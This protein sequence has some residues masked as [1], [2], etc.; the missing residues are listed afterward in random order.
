MPL[1][2]PPPTNEAPP[3]EWAIWYSQALNWKVFPLAPRE[4]TPLT[5]TGFHAA[6]NELAQVKRWWTEHP[7]AGIGIPAGVNQLVLV[8]FDPRKG[9]RESYLKL[10]NQ[11]PWPETARVRTGG[12]DR[13]LH[14]YFSS[15][16]L[17]RPRT[18][19]PG[20]DIRAGNSYCVAPPSLHPITGRAYVWEIT[21]Q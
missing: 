7:R 9:G 15:D 4:K 10:T 18:I 19:L 3:L 1:T 8:D 12:P 21:P 17:W 14:F 6:T 20:V 13:G 2:V 5:A 11:E 16:G